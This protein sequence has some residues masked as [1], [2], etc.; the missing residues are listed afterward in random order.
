MTEADPT[1]KP[2]VDRREI[3]D[4]AQMME[5]RSLNHDLLLWQAPALA[6]TAQA[7]LFT[8]ALGADVSRLAR[9]ISSCL[10]FIISCM[11]VL[12]MQRHYIYMRA[13]RREIA[14]LER[15][16]G[17]DRPVVGGWYERKILMP[18]VWMACLALIGLTALALFVIA[19]IWPIWLVGVSPKGG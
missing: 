19:I 5:A 14:R 15:V 1:N 2:Q 11:S 7:F 17:I 13:E 8:I 12:L 10:A 6:M 9:G 16:L 3:W 18:Y 4:A